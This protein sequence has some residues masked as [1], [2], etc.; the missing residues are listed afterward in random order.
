MG[1]KRRVEEEMKDGPR[2]FVLLLQKWR[3]WALSQSCRRNR[4]ELLG[5]QLLSGGSIL[6]FIM[7]VCVNLK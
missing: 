1:E 7:F 2:G 6:V 5:A 4:N 3:V